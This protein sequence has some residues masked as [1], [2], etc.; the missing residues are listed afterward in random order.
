M[1]S[2]ATRWIRSLPNAASQPGPGSRGLTEP[3]SAGTP[4]R[5][6]SASVWRS[7]T[8]RSASIA[9][10]CGA[11]TAG[12]TR[13]RVEDRRRCRCGGKVEDDPAVGASGA[14]GHEPCRGQASRGRV[15][16]RRAR[17]LLRLRSFGVRARICDGWSVR[18]D[19]ERCV[20][21]VLHG[22][23]WVSRHDAA[24]ALLSG[25]TARTDSSIVLMTGLLGVARCTG[26]TSET[27]RRAARGLGSH[28]TLRGGTCGGRRLARVACRMS[29]TTS[30]P[31]A[32]L[33]QTT[34]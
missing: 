4:G 13:S 28:T 1:G 30:W 15:E 6:T 29:R 23:L 10:A 7:G 3:T 14:E 22:W 11:L 9:A 31:S 8:T 12:P 5:T 20:R 24:H 16:R 18:V 21:G 25:S 32:S 2:G 27:D 26:N 34:S 33:G 17:L 19:P